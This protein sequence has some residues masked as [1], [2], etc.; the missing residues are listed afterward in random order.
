MGARSAI[1]LLAKNKASDE[2]ESQQNEAQ[3]DKTKHQA[4]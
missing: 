3:Q 2:C 1:Q 4:L